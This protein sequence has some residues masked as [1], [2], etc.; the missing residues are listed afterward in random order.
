[1]IMYTESSSS[2]FALSCSSMRAISPTMT[3]RLT[4]TTQNL[5]VPMSRFPGPRGWWGGRS[6]RLADDDARRDI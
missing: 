6:I 2:T 1:M 3:T 5:R 4:T